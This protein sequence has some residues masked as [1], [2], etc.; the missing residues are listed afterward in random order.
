[1]SPVIASEHRCILGEGPIW[2]T[3]TGLWWVDI[4]GKDIH[5]LGSS[6]RSWQTSERVSAIGEQENG[7]LICSTKTGLATFNPETGLLQPFLRVEQSL[8]NNRCNDGKVAP[9]GS[10]WFGTMDDEERSVTG[11]LYR[12]NG[13]LRQMLTGIMIPNTLAWDTDRGLFYFADSAEQIIWRFQYGDGAL[14][15]REVFVS[16]K[17]TSMYP[18][19]S[20]IDS[21]GGLWNAQW[22]GSRVV[23]YLPNGEVDKIIELP[24]RRPTSCC[25]GGPK[26]RTLFITT[27]SIGC[28][29][30]HEP[31]A[32][33][34]FAIE[35]SHTGL[36]GVLFS[37]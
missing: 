19:G 22:D 14:S 29:P 24:A 21:E 31:D 1:M 5:N 16:L 34:T 33:K 17:G 6:S 37:R 2:S 18:D 15:N 10:F 27:A 30:D 11:S 36:P 3:N 9:D 28:H 8:E 23:R 7:T 35:L 25:F 12:Y 32:G 13:A 4:K 26:L 20:C